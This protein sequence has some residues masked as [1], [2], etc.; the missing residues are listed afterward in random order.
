[1]FGGSM[2][3]DVRLKENI[4]R[5]G[6]SP[7][8]IPI[9]EFN[10]IGGKNRYSGVIAQDLLKTNPSVVTVDEKSGYYKV[11]YDKIDANMYILN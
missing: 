6:K 11:N 4:K 9:Y 7:S 5:T 10:Y 1:M 8:G 3:S 2:W